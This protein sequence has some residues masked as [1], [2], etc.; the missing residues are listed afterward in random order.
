M[1]EIAF[2]VIGMVIGG[3]IA[4]KVAESENLTRELDRERARR[5]Q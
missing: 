2:F 3:V 4:T 5:D 1:K